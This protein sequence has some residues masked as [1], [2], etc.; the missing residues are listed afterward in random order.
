MASKISDFIRDLRSIERYHASGSGFRSPETTAY[1]LAR[2]RA[3]G[4]LEMRG[5]RL[6]F[7]NEES[8][9]ALTTPFG[10]VTF[11]GT[12]HYIRGGGNVSLTHDE[13]DAAGRLVFPRLWGIVS[14][15]N[16]VNLWIQGDASPTFEIGRPWVWP[17]ETVG[18]FRPRGG[19]IIRYR[20]FAKKHDD[21]M[22]QDASAFSQLRDGD[23]LVLLAS[24]LYMCIYPNIVL[25][26]D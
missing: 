21:K 7:I 14:C 2:S 20:L 9:G 26:T 24:L 25:D 3:G 23:A 10:R 16:R 5:R 22:F 4:A 6:G 17:Q 18:R 12:R 19:K 11:N 1:L 8:E 15:A 13:V